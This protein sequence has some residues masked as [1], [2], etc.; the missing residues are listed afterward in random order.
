MHIVP[1]FCIFLL[2]H[3]L[4]ASDLYPR[5][6]GGNNLRLEAH[7]YLVKL[8]INFQQNY[9]K[10]SCSGSILSERWIISA[11]HCVIHNVR[12]VE[13][14]QLRHYLVFKTI[15][16]VK[17]NNIFVYP[18][19]KDEKTLNNFSIEHDLALLKTTNCINFDRFTKPIQL[20][21]KRVRI[22]QTAVIAGYGESEYQT[23]LPKEGFNVVTKCLDPDTNLI[24]T[25]S[26]VRAG[27]GDSGGAL[28]SKGRL[29]GVTNLSCKYYKYYVPCE[30]A[31]VDVSRHMDWIKKTIQNNSNE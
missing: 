31:Y 21:D 6:Y 30:T 11:A 9:K 29:V 13:V 7:K 26:R 15:A 19:T 12:N 23:S 25:K 8:R 24:C 16:F 20:A 10:L 17:E 1:F 28:V 3:S 22:G 5:V 18:N 14:E 4:S 27:P 2:I